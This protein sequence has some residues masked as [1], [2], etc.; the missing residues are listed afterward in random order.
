MSCHVH[1]FFIN[2]RR[3]PLDIS[4]S[5]ASLILGS[6]GSSVAL[7]GERKSST[8]EG[9]LKKRFFACPLPMNFSKAVPW[10]GDGSPLR[11]FLRAS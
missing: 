5:D 3:Q 1:V 11:L 6:S 7:G 10:R 8:P 2:G 4:R 9:T